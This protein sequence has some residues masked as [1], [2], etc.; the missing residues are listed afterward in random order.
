M[1]CRPLP[2]RQVARRAHEHA[3][4]TRIV[5]EQDD[6]TLTI[7]DLKITSQPTF[8]EV[9]LVL[10]ATSPRRNA[11]IKATAVTELVF[12]GM[13]QTDPQRSALGSSPSRSCRRSVGMGWTGEAAN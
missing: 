5:S 7:D 8:M 4:G 3:E 12:A 10:S 1:G 13:I 11:T 6:V 2:G 9:M